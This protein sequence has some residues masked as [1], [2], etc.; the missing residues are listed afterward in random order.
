M[1]LTPQEPAAPAPGT[2]YSNYS[3]PIPT[4]KSLGTT[5]L[6][7]M[8]L[9]WVGFGWGC[10]GLLSNFV[11]LFL[12]ESNLVLVLISL[13]IQFG[14]TGLSF[15]SAFGISKYKKWGIKLGWTSIGY[16]IF[17][18]I[19][20]SIISFL[21]FQETKDQLL[22]DPNNSINNESTIMNATMIATLSFTV[23]ISV[24]LIVTKILLLNSKS[25]KETQAR[26]FE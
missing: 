3:A 21:A 1:D 20:G 22:I 16:A 13:L 25:S 19:S 26:Y 18:L 5:L 9:E 2:Y 10:F 4:R 23:L 14:S 7:F 11:S 17:A 8:I 24:G 12:N 6:I 15:S